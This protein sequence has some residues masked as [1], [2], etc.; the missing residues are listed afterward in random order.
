M[1]FEKEAGCSY[2]AFL[3]NRKAYDSVC[4]GIVGTTR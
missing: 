4:G 3:V 2:L 1:R